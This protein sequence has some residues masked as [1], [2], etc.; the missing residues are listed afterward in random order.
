[1]VVKI[2]IRVG[3]V[4]V[5]YE[6]PEAFLD[7]KLPALVSDLS[8]LTGAAGR[9]VEK[10]GTGSGSGE[11]ENAGT[12]ASFLQGKKVKS[13]QVRKFLATA[14]WLQIGGAKSLKTGEVTSALKNSHQGRLSNPSDCLKKNTEKGFCE[15]SGIEFYVT[16]EGIAELGYPPG[17]LL[18]H[19]RH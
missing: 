4:E 18:G 12:L 6:G 10:G 1:M 8:K 2:K 11:G 7:K 3:D 13:S 14:A 16:E 15:K 5:D 9:K 17:T 19:L